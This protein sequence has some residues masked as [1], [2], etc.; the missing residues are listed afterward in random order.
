MVHQNPRRPKKIFDITDSTRDNNALEQCLQSYYA[1]LD[2]RILMERLERYIGDE[3]VLRLIGSYLQRLVD[4]DGEY[5]EVRWGISLGSPLSPL[6]GAIYLQ[7]L[8]EA[9]ARSDIEYVRYMDDWVILAPTR[10]K[11]RRAVR[12][13]NRLLDALK[14]SKHP[15]KTSLGRTDRGFDFLGYRFEATGLGLAAQTKQRF[16]ERVTRLYEQGAA[17]TRIGDYVR[18]WLIWARSG[19]LEKVRDAFVDVVRTQ[20][21]NCN[22]SNCKK[23]FGCGRLAS[24][25]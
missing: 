4:H 5:R 17:T 9:M 7:P 8:D 12:L 21:K 16:V 10:W 3:R 19:G 1:S 2:H 24:Y 15:D 6:M 18:R 23:V 14:L 22:G 25:R 11:L 13:V 20:S